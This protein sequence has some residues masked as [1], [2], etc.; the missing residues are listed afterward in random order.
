M[1]QLYIKMWQSSFY[2]HR[3]HKHNFPSIAALCHL[4]LIKRTLDR[5]IIIVITVVVKTINACPA[6]FYHSLLKTRKEDRISAGQWLWWFVRLDS[7]D[8][9]GRLW[10]R[11]QLHAAR[12]LDLP[13]SWLSLLT[14]SRPP[15]PWALH[16]AV[17]GGRINTGVSNKKKFP[18]RRNAMWEMFD[19]LF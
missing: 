18:T 8:W 3:N 16:W 10:T 9:E 5:I 14:L 1:F 17:L 7:R 4:L 15:Q 12:Q 19:L 11:L 2:L 13:L 6:E